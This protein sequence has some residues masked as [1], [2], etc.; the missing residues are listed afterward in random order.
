MISNLI[1]SANDNTQR[2]TNVFSV[3]TRQLLRT[4]RP[5]GVERSDR[6]KTDD[7]DYIVIPNTSFSG[8]VTALARLHSKLGQLVNTSKK[9]IVQYKQLGSNMLSAEKAIINRSTAFFREMQ[10]FRDD[11]KVMFKNLSLV[12][13]GAGVAVA[14]IGEPEKKED[15]DEDSWLWKAIAALLALRKAKDVSR[16]PKTPTP[17]DPSKTKPGTGIPSEKPATATPPSKTPAPATPE[18]LRTPGG[19]QVPANDN[20]SPRVNPTVAANDNTILEEKK[21]SIRDRIKGLSGTA[22]LLKGAN[23]LGILA[24]IADAV[25]TTHSG[26][27]E[28]SNSR[29]ST[30]PEASAKHAK[31]AYGLFGRAGGGVGGALAG[32]KLGAVMGTAVTPL[33]GS[34]AGGVVGGI[35][36]HMKGGELGE[37]IG[38]ALY[39]TIEEGWDFND[40][41]TH[42]FADMVL[43]HKKQELEERLKAA[44]SRDGL[45]RESYSRDGTGNMPGDNINRL[46]NEI[47]N[48]EQR[49]RT[50][51]ANPKNSAPPAVPN[52]Q[53]QQTPPAP[54]KPHAP[55]SEAPPSVPPA[56]SPTLGSSSSPAV[57]TQATA[58]SNQQ[59]AALEPNI[60]Y[61]KSKAD[62]TSAPNLTPESPQKPRWQ[63]EHRFPTPEELGPSKPQP[64]PINR[65]TDAPV[66]TG[67]QL[68]A[69]SA[70]VSAQQ[71]ASF[72]PPQMAGGTFSEDTQ[73][74]K[75]VNAEMPN[76]GGAI[77]PTLAGSSLRLFASYQPTQYPLINDSP[78]PH[79]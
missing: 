23:A 3:K 74:S 49:L 64:A 45:G 29:K 58:S 60:Q 7:R 19:P 9:L 39:A 43:R 69:T 78:N 14:G 2:K 54:K 79:A 67:N 33:V 57:P 61:Q 31:N 46:T 30:D 71:L 13:A 40:A 72:L 22:T 63:E 73:E 56:G 16:I 20:A 44:Q 62:P 21:T 52:T 66:T 18:R 26:I 38:R 5:S 55:M 27:E 10:S 11:L 65:I 28:L 77:E 53:Q 4:Q 50:N 37:V 12:G 6:A 15:P 75:P 68:Y 48:I 32:A 47:G 51:P 24:L 25:M 17:T 76:I 59:V 36:G 34:V 70:A 41:L 1:K 42:E 8:I 35:I